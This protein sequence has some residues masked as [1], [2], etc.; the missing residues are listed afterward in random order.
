MTD[1]DSAGLRLNRLHR[2]KKT[3]ARLALEVHSH[4]EVPAGCG[5]VVLRWRAVDEPV[6]VRFFVQLGRKDFTATVD[7]AALT[8]MRTTLSPG[9][10]VLT[11]AFAAS[12]ATQHLL[13]EATLD[14]TIQTATAPR[15]R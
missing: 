1:D 4:C 5:G 15:A 8:E 13:C 14:P 9:A 3:S 12:S 6:G 11:L 2:F 10:H 7:G